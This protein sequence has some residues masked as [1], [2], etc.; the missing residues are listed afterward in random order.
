VAVG[1]STGLVSLFRA[2]PPDGRP[3]GRLQPPLTH[4]L[5]LPFRHAPEGLRQGPPPAVRPA[6]RCLV[7]GA[8]DTAGEKAKEAP[9]LHLFAATSAAAAGEGSGVV[10][11]F[12]CS[13]FSQFAGHESAGVAGIAW[14]VLDDSEG[15]LCMAHGRDHQIVVGRD[16]AVYSFT[17]EDR[18][19]AVGFEGRKQA[20][21]WVSSSVPGGAPY[22]AVASHNKKSARSEVSLYDLRNKFV[23]FT[24]RLDPKQEV[25]R[26]LSGPGTCFVL[27]GDSKSGRL[28]GLIRLHE[29]SVQAKLDLLFKMNHYQHAILLAKNARFTE[30]QVNKIYLMFGDHKLRKS[31]WE[32]AVEQYVQTIG[33]TEPSRIV[34]KFLDAQQLAPL[35]VYLERLHVLDGG[36]HASAEQTTLLLHCL[37]K[38]GDPSCSKMAQLVK[39][40]ARAL[41][42]RAAIEVLR[43]AGYPMQA[44]EVARLQPEGPRRAEWQLQILLDLCD[45]ESYLERGRL[46]RGGQ[47]PTGDAE[48][49]PATAAVE[50]VRSLEP[51]M[52]EAL[53]LAY[54]RRLVRAAGAPAVAALLSD[55]C[56]R[57]NPASA[58][59][60]LDLLAD[61]PAALLSLLEANLTR[62][63]DGHRALS[64]AAADTLLELLLG[65]WAG[66]WAR[67]ASAGEAPEHDPEP[68]LEHALDPLSSPP[69]P[70]RR[71]LAVPLAAAAAGAG[72]TAAAAA[73]LNFLECDRKVAPYDLR[74]ALVLVQAHAFEAGEQ[75]VLGRLERHRVSSDQVLAVRSGVF[76]LEA[77]EAAVRGCKK[78][79]NAEARPNPN[80]WLKTLEAIVRKCQV[81][82]Q[83]GGCVDQDEL[84]DAHD[85]LKDFLREIDKDK[86]LPSVKVVNTLA[87]NPQLPLGVA[88][89]YLREI[90]NVSS[91]QITAHEASIAELEAQTAALEGSAS[92]DT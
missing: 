27:V 79:S 89:Q 50:L 3:A 28:K 21:A 83:D 55:L 87:S 42:A 73:V 88:S 2:P 86:I 76:C 30:P 25:V 53:V 24:H 80:L 49:K 9:R 62:A 39:D 15:G 29:R 56:R 7:F 12:D 74:R 46:E 40:H 68:S 16:D 81:G 71:P 13:D 34:R 92:E 51:D 63:R 33:F 59:L 77:L 26:L 1:Y 85:L 64:Q 54:G 90:A 37:V 19:G 31:D 60:F 61:E 4:R 69:P 11:A 43:S 78:E 22:L 8:D 65:Q 32:G 84:E 72:E 91:A 57:T 52:A 75:V 36:A 5:P 82:A 17:S 66:Q 14:Q 20:L 47:D 23:A 35:S 10:A 18:A 70:P 58:D 45:T 41:D 44:L 67:A 48:E 6:V 38:L